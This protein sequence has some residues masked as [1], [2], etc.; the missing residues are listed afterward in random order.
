[1]ELKSSV[2][3][4]DPSFSKENPFGADVADDYSRAEELFQKSKHP[5]IVLNLKKFDFNKTLGFINFAKGLNQN[6][7]FVLLAN[8]VDPEDLKKLTNQIS[9]FKIISKATDAFLELTLQEAIAEYDLK[10]QNQKLL[11]LFQDQNDKLVEL[12]LDLEERVSKRQKYLENSKEKLLQV[13]QN[14]KSLLE[15]LFAI[16]KSNSISEI[17]TN[18]QKALSINHK[19]SWVRIKFQSQDTNIESMQSNEFSIFATDLIIDNR[20]LGKITFARSKQV[21]FSEEDRQFLTQISQAI[22]LAMDRLNQIEKSEV[23]KQQWKSTFDAI[24][25]PVAVIRS[26]YE[27]V[28]YNNSFSQKSI[29]SIKT[30]SKCYQALFARNSPCEGCKLASSF[31]L[32]IAKTASGNEVR[33]DVSS[34]KQDTDTFVNTYRD[35]SERERVERQILESS[36]MAE[37]G[38]IGGSIAHELN[39][40]LAGLLTF[41]QM[42]KSELKSTE[43][44]YNDI[45]EMEISANKCKDIIQNLLSFTRK[46]SKTTPEKI[47]LSSI[48]DN[49]IKIINIKAQSMGVKIEKFISKD[50]IEILGQPNLLSQALINILQNALDAIAEKKKADSN[51]APKIEIVASKNSS[52]IFLD[53]IDNGL[54]LS[55]EAQLKVFTPFF[56]TKSSEL[57]RGL[58]LTVAFQIIQ[59]HAGSIELTQ[60]SDRKTRARITF[61]SSF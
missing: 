16:Q 52:N 31:Q 29:P 18:L 45:V 59:D 33:Y 48:I 39:N 20:N 57:H 28:D 37:L 10:M 3:I 55:D 61:P 50:D 40:P 14:F 13:N 30:K 12:S 1:M 22:S 9:I 41:L 19:L 15:A 49:T 54:G 7:Q 36:K 34:H 6:S 42:I 8:Q 35:I 38:T 21:L 26:D 25:E 11:Q 43:P 2:L 56:S 51:F 32:L 46:S 5:A 17:E 27:L 53:V 58:G 44:Y 4:V 24:L 60:L 23:L 47:N